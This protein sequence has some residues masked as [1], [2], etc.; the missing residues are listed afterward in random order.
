VTIALPQGLQEGGTDSWKQGELARHLKPIRL[1]QLSTGSSSDAADQS[2]RVQVQGL[3]DVLTVHV[4]VGVVTANI[5]NLQDPVLPSDYPATPGTMQLT[6]VVRN[7]E[8]PPLYLRE[9]FQDP[10]NTTNTDAP[11]AQEIPFGWSF[12]PEGADEV[13]VDIII[14]QNAWVAEGIQGTLV[15][16]VTVSYTGEWQD[17]KAVALALGKVRIVPSD[18]GLPTIATGGG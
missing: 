4:A 15:C 17:P 3:S 14:P 2:F 18:G 7:P 1:A 8:L 16:V 5:N 11:Q 9:V 10:T 13:R 12:E 6:P